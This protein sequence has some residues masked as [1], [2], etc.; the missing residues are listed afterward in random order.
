MIEGDVNGDGKAD[1]SIELYDPDHSIV[2]T[3]NLDFILN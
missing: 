3:Q 1:L 2:L